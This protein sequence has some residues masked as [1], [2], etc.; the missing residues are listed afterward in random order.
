VQHR[1]RAVLAPLT[2]VVIDDA[3]RGQVMRQH[4]PGTAAAQ[5]IEDGVEDVPLGVGLG[6][7]PRFGVGHE[8]LEHVPFFVTEIGRLRL[9][10]VHA[11]F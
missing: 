7:A 8:M 5:Q 1:P 11:S 3:P 2:K 6:T 9:S 10:W 4:P